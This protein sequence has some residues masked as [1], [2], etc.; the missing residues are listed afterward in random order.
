MQ[1]KAQISAVLI[2][3]SWLSAP[4]QLSERPRRILLPPAAADLQHMLSYGDH[5]NFEGL[6]VA[7]EVTAL[8]GE[9]EREREG[10]KKQ[11]HRLPP[12]HRLH[13]D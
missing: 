13:F 11:N 6:A 2:A 9:R 10:E 12:V 8:R 1:L 3:L 4:L 5:D 7:A